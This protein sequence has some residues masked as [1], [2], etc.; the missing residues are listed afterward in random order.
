M[1]LIFGEPIKEDDNDVYL[2]VDVEAILECDE[3]SC[4]LYSIPSNVVNEHEKNVLN[5]LGRTIVLDALRVAKERSSTHLNV[6]VLTDSKKTD[7]GTAEDLND[8]FSRLGFKSGLV[9]DEDVVSQRGH[10]R[11]DF[12]KQLR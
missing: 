5:E 1:V 6:S 11:F 7:T 10:V 8:Q 12:H 2:G 4:Y 3:D 9:G